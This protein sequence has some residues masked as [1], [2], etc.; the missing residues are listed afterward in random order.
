MGELMAMKRF[1][2]AAAGLFGNTLDATR[3]V[4][5]CSIFSRAGENADLTSSRPP[6]GV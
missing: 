4:E 5:C 3:L 2:A 1:E 6:T